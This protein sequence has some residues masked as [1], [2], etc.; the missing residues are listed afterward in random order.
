M[1]TTPI[2]ISVIF[3]VALAGFAV[4]PSAV[5]QYADP[6]AFILV[7]GGTIIVTLMRS[8]VRP[9][10]TS[11]RT[12]SRADI[13]TAARTEALA[14][15]FCEMATI[16]RRSGP[17]A[18]EHYKIDDDFLAQGIARFVDGADEDKLIHHLD[19]ELEVLDEDNL[20][21]MEVWRGWIDHAPAMGLIGTIAGLV[22]VL[23]SLAD[24]RAI[25]PS[26]GL[27]LLTT[28][29]GAVLANFIGVPALARLKKRLRE[30]RTYKQQMCDGLC[31]LARGGT[32]RQFREAFL[33]QLPAPPALKLVGAK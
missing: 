30:D 11:L 29:Y 25:G 33:P 1:R 12:L 4:A 13:N 3:A 18:L 19:R 31:I 27:A 16:V 2:L 24:P 10:A 5:A 28:L 22:G 23:G 7:F 20:S 15:S 14:N 17:I 9:F 26:L 6:S 21:Q 32:A 8:G